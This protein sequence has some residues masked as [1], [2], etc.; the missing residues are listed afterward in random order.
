MVLEGNDIYY[1]LGNSIYKT[2]VNATT[3]PA[4]ELFTTDAGYL[5]GL[6]VRN[7]EI[8]VLDANFSGNSKLN[9]YDLSA[10]TKKDTKE[11]ALGAS[12][13]YFN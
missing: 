3:L 10:K 9:I 7:N 12:K 13:I 11:V 2:D 5:Y 4:S 1:N 6:G 8:F